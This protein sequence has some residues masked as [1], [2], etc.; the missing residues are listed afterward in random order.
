M[1]GHLFYALSA[2]RKITFDIPRNNCAPV[3]LRVGGGSA[4]MSD[5]PD[6]P[7]VVTDRTVE[8]LMRERITEKQAR[9]LIAQF[10]IN[11]PAL[12]R[13]AR[14]IRRGSSN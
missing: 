2:A 7:H 14:L 13:E 11:W 6:I 3:L 10:G 1:I 9:E 4:A 5:E 12:I 8:R